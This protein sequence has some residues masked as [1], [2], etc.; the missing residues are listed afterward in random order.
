MD[1][2]INPF[3]KN[4]P[5]DI[6]KNFNLVQNQSNNPYNVRI[7]SINKGHYMDDTAL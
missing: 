5:L 6:R 1:H 7:S 3:L 2:A 4:F